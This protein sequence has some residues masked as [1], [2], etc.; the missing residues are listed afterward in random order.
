LVLIRAGDQS[1]QGCDFS[2]LIPC[3]FVVESAI[4]GDG[5]FVIA[6]RSAAA[7]CRCPMCGGV[8]SRVH[9]QYR[10]RL[11]GQGDRSRTIP[12]FA[13]AWR[14][15]QIG[16]RARLQDRP[17]E[18]SGSARKRALAERG[19]CARQAR[20]YELEWKPWFSRPSAKLFAARQRLVSDRRVDFPRSLYRPIHGESAWPM[21]TGLCFLALFKL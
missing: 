7:V 3:G 6:M 15:G 1:H 16:P 14:T 4:K 2:E 10:R 18:R 20:N 9:S 12:V 5:G 11:A 19:D 21:K 13:V 8:C 17:C